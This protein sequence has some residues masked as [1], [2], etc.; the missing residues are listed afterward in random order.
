MVKLDH[1]MVDILHYLDELDDDKAIL[2]ELLLVFQNKVLPI[3]TTKNIQLCVF[4][5]A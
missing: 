1:L 2:D 3:K 5:V 4:L